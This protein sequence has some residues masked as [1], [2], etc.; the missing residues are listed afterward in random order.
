MK[1]MEC[2]ICGAP[3]KKLQRKY[4]ET[5]KIIAKREQNAAS[6]KKKD[7]LSDHFSYEAKICLSCTRKRCTN[8]LQTLSLE[9]KTALLA[10]VTAIYPIPSP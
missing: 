5:C 10:Q 8:C 2:E 7:D 6:K 9:Q 4:C 3:L 1:Y